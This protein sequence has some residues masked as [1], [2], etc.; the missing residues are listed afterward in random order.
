MQKKYPSAG[1]DNLEKAKESLGNAK[2][3][4]DLNK[5]YKKE[6]K[7]LLKLHNENAFFFSKEACLLKFGVDEAN[8]PPRMKQEIQNKFSQ[9]QSSKEP[10]NSENLLT[11]L[12]SIVGDL[13]N[14]GYSIGQVDVRSGSNTQSAGGSGEEI[15]DE[16]IVGSRSHIDFEEHYGPGNPGESNEGDKVNSEPSKGEVSKISH[17]EYS[18]A[19]FFKEVPSDQKDYFCFNLFTSI[20]NNG[21]R[22]LDK[23]LADAHLRITSDG[24]GIGGEDINNITGESAHKLDASDIKFGPKISDGGILDY[25]SIVARFVHPD[26]KGK[27]DNE[28]RV[29]EFSVDINQ[30]K[31]ACKK[32]GIPMPDQ[33]NFKELK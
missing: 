23:S 18:G 31:D 22:E 21:G 27:P 14:Q 16:E 33:L 17:W 7:N 32:A 11:E 2:N 30:I 20:S 8:L 28:Q 29:I 1:K 19:E 12:E 6:K 9:V 5:A 25:K 3:V 26:D 4:N 15:N 13:K 24:S 10:V